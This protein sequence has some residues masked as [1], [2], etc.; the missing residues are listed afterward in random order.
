MGYWCFGR[1]TKIW[2]ARNND[3]SS[4]ADGGWNKVIKGL[5]KNK[6]Y[7]SVT[8]VKRVSSSTNG[9]FYHGC[10]TGTNYTL[11]LSN[12]TENRNPYF[13]SF[14]ISGL[15]QNV[16][17]VSVGYIRANN[18]NSKTNTNGGLYRLD[19]GAKIRSYT[20]YKMGTTG[21][22]HHRTYL[23]YSTS[24][25]CFIGLDITGF[26]EVCSD[27]PTLADLIGKTGTS[28]SKGATGATGALEGA[29]DPAG[30]MPDISQ[31]QNQQF[32]VLKTNRLDM[33]GDIEMDRNGQSS[34]MIK[35]NSSCNIY[36]SSTNNMHYRATGG[37]P[38]YKRKQ[39]CG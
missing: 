16:W 15:P 8:Y 19:T 7:M 37:T 2:K 6:G 22:Q 29:A 25:G 12:N 31:I 18:D 13:G 36:S 30:S 32:G 14:N 26:Y 39:W 33:N 11:N 23:Y 3:A 1:R 34:R 28:G 35:F 9:A 21:V 10:G 27:S 38:L 17:C 4:N 24:Q 20:D 5:D